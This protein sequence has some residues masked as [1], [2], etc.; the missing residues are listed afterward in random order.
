MA[1]PR[2]A[3]RTMDTSFMIAVWPDGRKK[4]RW[5]AIG[6]N[7]EDGDVSGDGRRWDERAFYNRIRWRSGLFSGKGKEVGRKKRRKG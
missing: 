6:A 1:R 5:R 4:R 2:V 3:R 7:E